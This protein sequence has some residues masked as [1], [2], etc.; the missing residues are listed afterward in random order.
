MTSLAFLA[1][2][3][4]LGMKPSYNEMWKQTIRVDQHFD[5][6]SRK[7]SFFIRS[8][9]YL[10][11]AMFQTGESNDT[12]ISGWTREYKVKDLSADQ[13]PWI[14]I[15]RTIESTPTDSNHAMNILASIR[16]KH[17]PL[18]MRLTYT[19]GKHGLKDA[20]SVYAFTSTARTI[21]LHWSFFPDSVLLVPI[22]FT[23]VGADSVTES[24]EAIFVQPLEAVDVKKNLAHVSTRSTLR[25]STTIRASQMRRQ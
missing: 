14:T 16:L 15:T 19:G 7:G 8:S 11:G 3:V 9:D 1:C 21:S 5:Y 10:N 24:V 6:N 25:Q 22:D 13:E 17:R 18:S 12:L 2:V 20:G 4:W 23:V